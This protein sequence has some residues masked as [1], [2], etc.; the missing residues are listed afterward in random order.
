[1]H[2]A[3]LAASVNFDVVPFED[4]DDAAWLDMF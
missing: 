1:M 3:Q 4:I 2:P